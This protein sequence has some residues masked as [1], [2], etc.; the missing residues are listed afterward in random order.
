[1]DQK[2]SK[3][4]PI[5]EEI[6]IEAPQEPISELT[7][8]YSATEMKDYFG[9]DEKV[10]AELHS[11]KLQLIENIS[12]DFTQKGFLADD[13]LSTD[14]SGNIRLKTGH[15]TDRLYPVYAKSL[16]SEAILSKAVDQI[17]SIYQKSFVND[18][19]ILEYVIP[20]LLRQ[21][22]LTDVITLVNSFKKRNMLPLRFQIFFILVGVYENKLDNLFL[23]GDETLLINILYKYKFH[24]ISKLEKNRLYDMVLSHENIELL[25]IVFHLFSDTYR[26]LRNIFPIYKSILKN[27][28]YLEKSEKKVFIESY[29]ETGKYME[30]YFLLKKVYKKKEI[31]DWLKQMK[32]VNGKMLP[33]SEK[34][35]PGLNESEDLINKYKLLKNDSNTQTLSPFEILHLLKTNISLQLKNDIFDA[36]KKIPYSYVNNR[37]LAVLYFFEMDYRKFLLY[38]ERAG[39]LRNHSECIYLKSMACIELGFKDDAKKLL[40]ALHEAFP[41]T[42]V[43]QSA[44]KRLD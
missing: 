36:Y 30:I 39:S 5:W 43:I 12:D 28:S 40:M 38:M 1:M 18:P 10:R 42:D 6:S 11:P 19:Q 15:F 21:S 27:F 22:R 9:L 7:Q 32:K 25:G 37:S 24:T 3:K 31:S 26:G 4:Q 35:F 2:T 13:F 8:S 20:I 41:H 29:K 34:T 16:E 23:T 44:L 14:L 33:S 17:L